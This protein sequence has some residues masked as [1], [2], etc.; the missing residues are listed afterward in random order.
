MEF[1]II[2]ITLILIML[3][4]MLALCTQD[5]CATSR[6]KEV[7][8]LRGRTKQTWVLYVLPP[9]EKER[10]NTT[11]RTVQNMGILCCGLAWAAARLRTSGRGSRCGCGCGWG[12][13][14]CGPGVLVNPLRC[15]RRTTS[16]VLYGTG[17]VPRCPQRLLSVCR[18]VHV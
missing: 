5:S 13:G 10:S 7:A 12:D 1:T 6:E 18:D 15:T 4:V 2:L 16:Y 8:I 14:G 9:A 3:I 17:V 11:W